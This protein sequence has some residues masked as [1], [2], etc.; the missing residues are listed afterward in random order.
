MPLRRKL[1]TTKMPSLIVVA[2]RLQAKFAESLRKALARELA[3]VAK[4]WRLEAK[5]NLSGR[6]NTRGLTNTTQYPGRCSGDLE[7]SL[8]H[9]TYALRRQSTLVA[10][11]WSRK[12]EEF[13][14]PATKNSEP[15]NYAK[16]LDQSNNSYGQYRYRVYKS[17]DDRMRKVLSKYQ[18]TDIGRTTW[19][20]T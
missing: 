10:A 15:F 9:R 13:N 6:C 12:F 19:L 20:R 18:D 3:A 2:E 5:M 11:G 14:R 4:Q 16:Y 7:R 1:T 17:L 8:T